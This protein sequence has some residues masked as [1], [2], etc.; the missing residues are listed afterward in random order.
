MPQEAPFLFR[1]L[2]SGFAE[3]GF[4]QGADLADLAAVLGLVLHEGADDHP[5]VCC[6]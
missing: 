3:R 1:G 4:R 5:Q 6:L 2:R